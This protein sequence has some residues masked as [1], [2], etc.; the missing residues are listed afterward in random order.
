MHICLYVLDEDIAPN[1][2]FLVV[3]ST[4]LVVQS[5]LGE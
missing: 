5:T 3:Q 4:F 1:P 2:I